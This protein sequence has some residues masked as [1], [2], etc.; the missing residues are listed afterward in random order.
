MNL[1]VADDGEFESDI[2][3]FISCHHGKKM[4]TYDNKI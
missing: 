4:P 3:F 2:H 1:W